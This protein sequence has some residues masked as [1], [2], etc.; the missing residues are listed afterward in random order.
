MNEVDEHTSVL[1]FVHE[2][3][4]LQVDSACCILINA[5]LSRYLTPTWLAVGIKYHDENS[6]PLL[7]IESRSFKSSINCDAKSG[8]AIVTV[9]AIFRRYRTIF[10]RGTVRTDGTAFRP[11]DVFQQLYALR[12]ARELSIKLSHSHLARKVS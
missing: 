5:Y 8:M 9:V 11:P 3:A 4:N 1:F 2:T 6:K 12:A 10:V 7:Q